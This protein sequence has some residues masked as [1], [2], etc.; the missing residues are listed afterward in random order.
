MTHGS[1]QCGARGC[2]PARR[3]P[4]TTG[5]RLTGA[6]REDSVDF[7]RSQRL[8]YNR[9]GRNSLLPRS[10]AALASR[11]DTSVLAGMA[12]GQP[13]VTGAFQALQAACQGQLP[14][15]SLAQQLEQ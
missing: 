11:P 4:G 7:Q 12:A 6:S 9:P 8:T 5:R 13:D 15:T 2:Q 1:S 3:P 14:L 10:A